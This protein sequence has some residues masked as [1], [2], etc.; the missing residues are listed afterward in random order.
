MSGYSKGEFGRKDTEKHL[1][2]VFDTF[3]RGVAYL[4]KFYNAEDDG[5][6]F[7]DQCLKVVEKKDGYNE[8]VSRRTYTD[9]YN[10]QTEEMYLRTFD[11][12]EC[13]DPQYDIYQ[14]MM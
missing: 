11:L 14:V 1:L 12:N 4:R 2:G 9:D 3:E 8:A 13:F 10:V 6:K 5:R 7:K